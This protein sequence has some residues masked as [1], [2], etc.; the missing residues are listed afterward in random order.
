[1]TEAEEGAL[2][3]TLR[4]ARSILRS[5]IFHVPLNSG[6]VMSRDQAASALSASGGRHDRAITAAAGAQQRKICWRMTINARKWPLLG[7][8]PGGTRLV[9]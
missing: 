7:Y 6:S 5:G 4:D 1:M 8:L 2:H 3:E 9:N